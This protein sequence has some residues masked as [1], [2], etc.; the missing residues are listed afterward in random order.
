MAQDKL[1]Q[2]S[3]EEKKSS[4]DLSD[5][6]FGL[7]DL[8]FD[9][10]QE[11]D[12]SFDDEESDEEISSPEKSNT[13]VPFSGS[14]DIDMSVLDD[15]DVSGSFHSDMDEGVDL[16][17]VLDEGIEEVED[18]LDSAQ[19]ISDRL[20]DDEEEDSLSTDFGSSMN[21]DDLLGDSDTGGSIFESD[22]VEDTAGASDDFDEP[23]MSSDD[24]L[25]SIDSPDDLAALGIADDDDDELDSGDS[26][27]SADIESSDSDI[28]SLFDADSVSY[29]SSNDD[30]DDF[31]P[32]DDKKL[33]DN[34]KAYTYNESSG[35]F[36]KII[37]IGVVVIAVIAAGMLWLS[38]GQDAEKSTVAKTEKQ[39]PVLKKE[40]AEPVVTE[41]TP[42]VA[43]NAEETLES[44]TDKP[45]PKLAAASSAPAGQIEKVS[46]KTG[47]SYVII[48]SF[49]DE[50]LAMDYA[51]KLS[52]DGKG[53][54][55][56]QPFGDS[57]R[58]R[59]S[60]ADFPSY[61]DAASQLNS[62]KDEFGSQ[63]WALKY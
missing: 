54:K 4:K 10:L 28:D 52:A 63:V 24:L 43:E 22:D 40:V 46:S 55:I 30:D 48:G 7:P 60:V 58:Y 9:E 50:D 59:V 62:F 56:I 21:Y 45:K 34:Y 32:S 13:K 61:G 37:V 31:S 44:T 41:E 27:F 6:D 15:I 3:E 20:G 49:I 18:V 53:V 19:L 17:S 16:D 1:N 25:A 23:V 12:M 33:P 57:K 39:P 5:D 11:L 38:G 14:D 42:V 35:G 51:N 47:Q 36:T 8:E 2:G 29:G 26:L